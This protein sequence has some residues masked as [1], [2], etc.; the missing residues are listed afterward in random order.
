MAGE[1]LD[2]ISRVDDLIATVP[3]NSICYVV[4]ARAHALPRGKCY[5]SHFQQAYMYLLLGNSHM[6]RSDYEVAI[7]SFQHA[8][9]RMRHSGGPLLLVVSLVS[10]LIGVLQ[11]IGSAHR[12]TDFRMEI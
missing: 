3:F 4:Q 1:H 6:M 9:A 8:R 10:F 11:C 2:A 12:L 5:H 7:Q